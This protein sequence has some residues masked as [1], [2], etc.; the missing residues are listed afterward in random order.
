MSPRVG[1]GVEGGTAKW[2]DQVMRRAGT[3]KGL[4]AMPAFEKVVGEDI[5]VPAMEMGKSWLREVILIPRSR[6]VNSRQGCLLRNGSPRGPGVP[7]KKVKS[8]L[9]LGRENFR[10]SP[11]SPKWNMAPIREGSGCQRMVRAGA[12]CTSTDEVD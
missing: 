5:G 7:V 9:F 12:A 8:G 6:R 10:D 1:L 11:R 3:M 2:R 4:L